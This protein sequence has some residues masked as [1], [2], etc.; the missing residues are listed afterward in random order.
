MSWAIK[1]GDC[2]SKLPFGCGLIGR[3]V[4]LTNMVVVPANSQV[5]GTTWGHQLLQWDADTHQ[6]YAGLVI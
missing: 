2:Q 6:A 4:V 5:I 3:R 1:L